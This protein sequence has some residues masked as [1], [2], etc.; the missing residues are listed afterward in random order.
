MQKAAGQEVLVHFSV[1]DTGIG[2]SRENISRLFQSFSQ[3]CFAGYR[4]PTPPEESHIAAA[5][6][7]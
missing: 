7:P 5:G 3:V 6:S 4:F 2:I 1:R